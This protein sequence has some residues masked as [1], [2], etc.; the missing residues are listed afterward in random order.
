M[1]GEFR[2]TRLDHEAI[3]MRVTNTRVQATRECA[4]CADKLADSVS[5]FTKS[6]SNHRSTFRFEDASV[7]EAKLD[8]AL[9]FVKHARKRVF[10]A[11]R[12]YITV[13]T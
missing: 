6:Q 2:G 12:G 10:A 3:R 13:Y 1:L 7:I 4:I 8:H 9:A 5:F 11:C